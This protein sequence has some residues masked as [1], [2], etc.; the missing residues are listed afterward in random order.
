MRGYDTLFVQRVKAVKHETPELRSF[1]RACLR[2]QA[3]ISRLALWFCVSRSTVYNWMTGQT[4]PRPH[5]LA[6][7]KRATELIN[8]DRFL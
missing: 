1:V 5:H 6:E 2:E 8:S 3:S 7:M 4:V